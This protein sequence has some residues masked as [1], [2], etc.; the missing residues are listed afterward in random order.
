MW[1]AAEGSS[2]MIRST[3]DI[4]SLENKLEDS[5]EASRS[6]K[7]RLKGTRIKKRLKKV[8]ASNGLPKGPVQCCELNFQTKTSLRKHKK[9]AHDNEDSDSEEKYY[10]CK[11]CGIVCDNKTDHTTHLERQHGIGKANTCPLCLVVLE[12]RVKR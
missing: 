7:Q 11:V 10:N 4:K 12:D 5:N 1:D 3:D 2:S 6:L 9:E 8:D